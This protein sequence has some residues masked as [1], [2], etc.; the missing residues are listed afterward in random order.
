MIQPIDV[1]HSDWEAKLLGVYGIWQT[2][3]KVHHLV[4]KR[5]VDMSHLLGNFIAASR[6]FC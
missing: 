4:A 2:D 6:D 1:T 5:L 3:G